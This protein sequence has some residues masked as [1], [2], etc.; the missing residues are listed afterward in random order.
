MSHIDQEKERAKLAEQEKDLKLGEEIYSISF[1]A[2]H[3]T[4]AKAMNLT[5]HDRAY[6]FEGATFC[7]ITQ[8]ILIVLIS[9][10]ILS[11]SYPTAIGIPDKPM[12]FLCR[13]ISTYLMHITL[14]P[15]MRM[16]LR[17]MKFIVNH[18]N[19]FTMYGYAFI[20]AF[21][22]FIVTLITEVLS[23]LYLSTLESVV[24][25]LVR[26]VTLA[27]V[28]KIGKFYANSLQKTVKLKNFHGVK[29]PQFTVYREI[30][31]KTKL[32]EGKSRCIWKFTLGVYNI[33]R[34]TYVVAGYYMLPY[35][36]I[37]LPYWLAQPIHRQEHE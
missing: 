11:S 14:E 1:R 36:A 32:K 4:T 12:P 22:F 19:E 34:M 33:S 28:A 8:T 10:F 2:Y 7:F 17:M 9:L 29:P 13:F 6:A 24:E 26:E 5:Y 20:C 31:N 15:Q 21:Q 27:A 3:D 23:V 25:I 37:F 35:L 16:S 30:R 18:P